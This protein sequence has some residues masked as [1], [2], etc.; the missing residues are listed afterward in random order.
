MHCMRRA[1]TGSQPSGSSTPCATI[2]ARSHRYAAT[3]SGSRSCMHA[4]NACMRCRW[5]PGVGTW[6]TLRRQRC[7][8]NAG[9]C[10]ESAAM[11]GCKGA[12]KLPHAAAP[13]S[14]AHA[15]TP[16]APGSSAHACTP[17]QRAPAACLRTARPHPESAAQCPS[18]PA[19]SACMHTRRISISAPLVPP[20]TMHVQHAWRTSLT[21][22]GS[23][24]ESSSMSI[25]MSPTL[26]TLSTM[27]ASACTAARLVPASRSCMHAHTREH[28]VAS[29]SAPARPVAASRPRMHARCRSAPWCTP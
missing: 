16:A 4:Y 19:P 17:A 20:H 1:R 6:F 23:P 11:R 29:A 8:R 10:S 21:R 5:A 3:A 12:R 18:A 26:S 15:C 27:W 7:W 22:C 13:D 9:H 14:S 2:S 28:D 25:S 24:E